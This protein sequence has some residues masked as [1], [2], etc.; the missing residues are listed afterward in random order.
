MTDLNIGITADAR[1]TRA[2][3]DQADRELL[4]VAGRLKTVRGEAE[5]T[6]REFGGIGRDAQDAARV[7][8][9][10]LDR[11]RLDL[12]KVEKSL[13]AVNDEFGGMGGRASGEF[14]VINSS[15]RSLRRGVGRMT[16][17]IARIETVSGE[18][19]RGVIGDATRMRRAL[20]SIGT[21]AQGTQ[22][23]IAAIGTGLRGAAGGLRRGTNFLGLGAGAGLLTGGLALPN[24]IGAGDDLTQA[25]G[26]LGLL[27]D[28]GET[29][30]A[31]L[32][33][34]RRVPREFRKVEDAQGRAEASAKR[35]DR[36]WGE[37]FDRANELRVPV[38]TLSDLTFQFGLSTETLGS[39]AKNTD[40]AIELLSKNIAI[41][42]ASGSQAA[43]NG[44]RQFVQG[45][46]RG[47]FEAEEYN[48]IGESISTVLQSIARG[49]GL[50]IT[51]L[52]EEMLKG[53]LT[54]QRVVEGLIA[55]GARVD[56]QFRTLPKSVRQAGIQIHNTFL[57]MLDDTNRQNK[58]T[59]ELVGLFD[60]LRNILK[61]PSSQAFF[62]DGISKAADFAVGLQQ[63]IDLLNNPSLKTAG[64]ALGIQA[65][66]L[67]SGRTGDFQPSGAVAAGNNF[68]EAIRNLLPGLRGPVPLPPASIVPRPGQSAANE[69]SDFYQDLL[70]EPSDD[71]KQLVDRGIGVTFDGDAFTRAV[72]NKE[73]PAG[74]IGDTR[75]QGNP[76]LRFPAFTGTA[77]PPSVTS[78]TGGALSA[79][80]GFSADAVNGVNVIRP[81]E[82]KDTLT[83]ARKGNRFASGTEKNTEQLVAEFRDLPS[84]LKSINENLLP[85]ILAAG[86]QQIRDL[87]D[88]FGGV[89]G[90]LS[91][92]GG[93]SSG[94]S[95][96]GFT[97]T[98]FD[99]L[100][101][102]RTIVVGS[103][104]SSSPT[105]TDPERQPVSGRVSLGS[106]ATGGFGRIPGS[107]G[108]DSVEFFGRATP[109]EPFAFGD[110]AINGIRNSKA[111]GSAMPSGPSQVNNTTNVTMNLPREPRSKPVV[112]NQ[113]RLARNLHGALAVAGQGRR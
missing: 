4:R 13:D 47:K 26:R 38:L 25:R 48:S 24:L 51:E 35:L 17:D 92:G 97:G 41:A 42:G 33:N 80:P 46:Q 62:A 76:Q 110:F 100:G 14:A 60:Q 79:T 22:T 108:T 75:F 28:P 3:F 93:S 104:R 8:G 69:I 50:T 101:T 23:R 36:Q 29:A 109:D 88:G 68:A 59:E 37:L 72:R 58:L 66:G 89:P 78:V 102:A 65:F 87:M 99:H 15:V 82:I 111:D 91:S 95:S 106:F 85:E 40:R 7:S 84:N 21:A 113:R 32:P 63:V 45:I 73:S 105:P 6:G 55:D 2:G 11:L 107:G 10:A 9:T 30:N 70:V 56:E 52:R 81:K 12:V 67:G 57:E 18:T 94:G 96:G 90:G 77:A 64:D 112:L 20:A 98:G 54:A 103:V 83:E 5:Q 27:P 39:E 86:Q 16:G 1:G 61:S 44:L 34:L 19:A 74:G 53:R 71:L 31:N 49:L 43:E